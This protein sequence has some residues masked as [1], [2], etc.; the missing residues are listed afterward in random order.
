MTFA[1]SVQR[2]QTREILDA[3]EA[4]P[5]FFA[6]RVLGWKPWSRQ[7]EIL[8]SARENR[9]TLVMSG[10]GVGKTRTL[11]SLICETMVLEPDAR[12]VCMASTYRQVHDALWGEVQ[13]LYRESR[14]P[15]GGRI[16]E[17]EWT[18][19]DGSRASIV[20]VD[21]PT[22]LQGIHSPR[23]LVVVDEAEG[24]DPRMWAAVDSLLSS[25]GSSLVVAFNPVT[26]SGYL[27]DASLNPGRW[28]V[29]R[30]SCLEHPNV[31]GDDETIVPGA[32]TNRWI[33]EVRTREGED[34]AFWSSRVLGRFPAAGSDS[35]ISVSEIEATE[36]AET[37]VREPRRIGLDVA[38]M[39]GDANVLVVLDESRRLIAV[40]SWRGEDL[41]QTTGRLIDA[42]RRYGVEGRNASVDSCGIGAGVVDRLRE[43]NVRVTAV[44][45][46]AGAAGDWSAILGRDAAFPNRRCELHSALRSLVRSKSISIPSKFREVVADL[47]SVRYWYDSRGRFTV[48][49][50]D[51]I[52]ARIRRS[53]DFGDALVIALGSGLARKVA[54]L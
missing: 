32:V 48:E 20:A 38:R 41:M 11:A 28:N 51:A 47:A 19:G 27:F 16:G 9:R 22:A 40:E 33:E 25:G 17:T 6:E 8:A 4:D 45:F 26:P 14:N 49:P 39:G 31:T 54:I 23:V 3:C 34:S 12:V 35:L 2:S 52:R 1:E 46:G 30:V 44:D 15:L 5:T 21:D 24:V 36:N 53:P 43:Q 42:M 7:R 18:I 37:G 50:K 13:K 29:I 10:H